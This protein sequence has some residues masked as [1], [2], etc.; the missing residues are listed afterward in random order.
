MATLPDFTASMTS[1]S[2]VISVAPWKTTFRLPAERLVS[3]S[4]IHLKATALD[5]GGAVMWG[6][7]SFFTPGLAWPEAGLFP[8][9]GAPATTNTTFASPPQTFPLV[10]LPPPLRPFASPSARHARAT[11]VDR[12]HPARRDHAAHGRRHHRHARRRLPALRHDLGL[13]DVRPADH[14]LLLGRGGWRV[15]ADLAHL[16][17]SGRGRAT[18]N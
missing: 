9:G 1:S 16:H 2:L 5:S 7:S 13:G 18:G 15:V 14:P 12:R 6:K 10:G 8:P 4:L 3:S 17:R 11:V